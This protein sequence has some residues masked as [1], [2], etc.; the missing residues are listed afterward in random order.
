MFPSGPQTNRNSRAASALITH[1][2]FL[3]QIQESII[4]MKPSHFQHSR[5]TFCVS[6]HLPDWKLF[7]KTHNKR[8]QACTA[9]RLPYFLPKFKTESSQNVI[10]KK[11]KKKKSR[12]TAYAV[13]VIALPGRTSWFY[14]NNQKNWW[15]TSK[16]LRFST[17]MDG[18]CLQTRRR[19]NPISLLVN[20]HFKWH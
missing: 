7:D 10:I 15:R 20:I 2:L 14:Q 4:Q 9:P 18:F 6:D 13:D 16:I 5:E 11:R 8:R 12:P 3:V 19:K 17:S 1:Q